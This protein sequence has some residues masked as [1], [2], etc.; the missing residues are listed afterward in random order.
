MKVE[1][2]DTIK[3]CTDINRMALWS[4]VVFQQGQNLTQFSCH[5]KIPKQKHMAQKEYCD[6]LKMVWIFGSIHFNRWNSREVKF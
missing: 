4:I 1:I 2:N 3:K 5:A 6:R